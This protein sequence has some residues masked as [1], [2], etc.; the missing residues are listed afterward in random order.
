MSTNVAELYQMVGKGKIEVGYD[1]DVILVD[2]QT[3]HTVRDENSWARVGWNPFRGMELTGWPVLTVVDGVPVF[4]RNE[5]T[6]PKGEI[7]VEPGSVGRKIVMM[8]WN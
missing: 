2:M 1:G 4:Q 8:P 7:L 3:K 5:E 6:G